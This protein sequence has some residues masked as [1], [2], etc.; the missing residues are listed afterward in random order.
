MKK[1]FFLLLLLIFSACADVS[2]PTA[3]SVTL[4]AQ[5]AFPFRFSTED[6]YGNTV[7]DA[8]LGGK[9]FYFVYYWTT[10]CPSCVSGMPGLAQLAEEYGDRVGFITLLGDFSTAGENAIRITENA[11]ASFSTVDARHGEFAPL[12]NLLN[13][14]FVPTTVLLDANGNVIGEQIVG[15]NLDVF[16]AAIEGALKQ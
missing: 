8:S 11:G 1:I 12:M 16:T 13:S 6:L 10:W 7:T 14:G 9:D 3:E 15:S 2:L 5:N 4:P